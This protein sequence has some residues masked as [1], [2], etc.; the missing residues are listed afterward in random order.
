MNE[1]VNTNET[2]NNET[3]LTVATPQH[4]GLALTDAGFDVGQLPAEKQLEIFR[5]IMRYDAEIEAMALRQVLSKNILG[6]PFDIMDASFRMIPDKKSETGEKQCI[7][8][9]LR[10]QETGEIVTCLKSSNNFN[11]VYPMYFESLR[12]IQHRPK[13]DYTFEEDPRYNFAG[14]NAIVFRKIQPQL[15]EKAVN[16]K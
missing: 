6:V 16:K 9:T 14:N 4:V 11:D 13:T 8:F 15:T 7:L 12:G 5:N 10:L 2:A 1:T 3:A